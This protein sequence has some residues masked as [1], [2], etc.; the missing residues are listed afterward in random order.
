M[1]TGEFDITV[2]ARLFAPSHLPDEIQR[3]L[4]LDADTVVLSS[5]EGLYETDLAAEGA[6]CAMVP[7]PTI[8]EQ[9]RQSIGLREEMPYFNS[10]MMLVDRKKWEEDGITGKCIDYYRGL[11]GR[12]LAFPDQDI[13]NHVLAGRIRTV[14]QGYNFF[15][16]YYYQSYDSLCTRAAWY[17]D[18]M[19]REDYEAAAKRPAVVHFAGAERPWIRG[20]RNPYRS[21]YRRYLAETPWNGMPLQKGQEIMMLAYHAMN[22]MTGLFP[23]VREMISAL[24]FRS[25]K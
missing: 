25:R 16:N 8:Y 7:E 18:R 12:G 6:I 23:P 1:N 5:V 9:T 24:Y 3:Y 10:G 22:V 20:N 4:Y 21:E 14:W 17:A 11:G 19:S 15:S 13:I 2:L